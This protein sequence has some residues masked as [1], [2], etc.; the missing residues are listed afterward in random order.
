MSITSQ[1]SNELWELPSDDDEEEVNAAPGAELPTAGETEMVAIDGGASLDDGEGSSIVSNHERFRTVSLGQPPPED[2]FEMEN[3]L[4]IEKALFLA[5]INVAGLDLDANGPDGCT[6][7]TRAAEAHRDDI[8][9]ILILRGVDHKKKA[10]GGN[11]DDVMTALNWA[12]ATPPEDGTDGLEREKTIELLETPDDVVEIIEKEES[13]ADGLEGLMDSLYDP[14][15][16]SKE[17]SIEAGPNGE[18]GEGEDEEEDEDA[19]KQAE[20]KRNSSGDGN[21]PPDTGTFDPNADWRKIWD[22]LMMFLLLFCAFVTPFEI[23]F[24]DH[25]NIDVMF[26][27]N[28][29][30][31]VLFIFDI[32]LAF[33][34]GYFHFEVGMWVTRKDLIINNYMKTWFPID[35]VSC[36]PFDIISTLVGTTGALAQYGQALRLIR[37]ARLGKLLR[38]LRA[39]RIL[40][41]WA[42]SITI[43]FGTQLL[44]KCMLMFC[45][46]NHWCACAIRMGSK[47][48][49]DRC[50]EINIMRDSFRERFKIP[51]DSDYRD[52]HVLT[53]S[54]LIMNLEDDHIGCKWYKKYR[55]QDYKQYEHCEYEWNKDLWYEAVSGK[56]QEGFWA[57]GGCDTFL[58]RNVHMS[59]HKGPR[60]YM[61][62]QYSV[63]MYWGVTA[64]KGTTEAARSNIEMWVGILVTVIGGAVYAIMIGDVANVFTNLDEAGNNFKKTID[65]LNMYMDENHFEYELQCKLR[66]YF[67]HCKTMLR[68]VY[69]NSVVLKMSPVL[70][71]EVA[72]KAN[73]GWVLKIGFFGVMKNNEKEGLVTDVSLALRAAVFIPQDKVVKTG[74]RN[75]ALMIIDRGM[76]TKVAAG[77]PPRLMGMGTSFGEDIILHLVT[78]CNR[79]R[80]YSV[81]A[82]TYLDVQMLAAGAF[83]DI[84]ESG[85]YPGS[86]KRIRVAATKMLF[87]TFFV[88]ELKLI[89]TMAQEENNPIEDMSDLIARISAKLEKDRDMDPILRAQMGMLESLKDKMNRHEEN[90]LQR[91]QDT[92]QTLEK[93]NVDQVKSLEVTLEKIVAWEEKF[94]KQVSKLERTIHSL[95]GLK[96]FGGGIATKTLSRAELRRQRMGL[97]PTPEHVGGSSLE[98]FE[99]KS[100]GDRTPSD[101]NSNDSA[102]DTKS[103]GG[104]SVSAGSWDQLLGSPG[105]L[106]PPKRRSSKGPSK[107]RMLIE[108]LTSANGSSSGGDSASDAGSDAGGI[109]GGT[110]GG[111]GRTNEDGS[112]V[113]RFSGM[114]EYCVA[115][116]LLARD[117]D[118]SKT[119]RDAGTCASCGADLAKDQAMNRA[120]RQ[121]V[122]VPKKREIPREAAPPMVAD[123]DVSDGDDATGGASGGGGGG[124]GGGSGGGSGS[125]GDDDSA[126]DSADVP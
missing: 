34:T 45:I 119:H 69:H 67:F 79:P 107:T 80:K 44:I 89:M 118:F 33:N 91:F 125:G 99:S 48:S 83:K 13:L 54:N 105:A 59:Y 43:S 20:M 17:G 18:G 28:Q 37:L 30:I 66:G 82:L 52:G 95:R 108:R 29:T 42:A 68:A 12:K 31:N 50:V 65:N 21:Y 7:L 25:N 55:N 124:H 40:N 41:R 39:S 56:Y 71:G 103:E 90:T 14:D 11:G 26:M 57:E 58:T 22:L 70:R 122:H 61:W 87:K 101:G 88:D 86:F 81:T 2:L 53:A 92:C 36:F 49:L 10:R 19:M 102:S 9:R 116:G 3:M 73:S 85:V 35:F 4:S 114:C 97:P 60:A 64:L 38:I 63:C 106:G 24:I 98:L 111:G 8:V 72:W 100:L 23:G 109:G 96:A 126:M 76:V 93:N 113:R 1:N 16:A 84:L 32:F 78:D 74:G 15:A 51:L 46:L 112:P 115:N 110:G 6:L 62:D 123:S 77:S 104:D 120:Q 94:R 5:T 47:M 75:D 27:I 117:V 121:V